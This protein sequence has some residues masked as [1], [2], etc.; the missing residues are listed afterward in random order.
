MSGWLKDYVALITGGRSRASG[1]ASPKGSSVRGRSGDD[2]S[3]EFRAL[4]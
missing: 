3:A 1:R 4:D 2:Q